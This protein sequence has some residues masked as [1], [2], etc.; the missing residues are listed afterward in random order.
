[1]C[2]FLQSRGYD[3]WVFTSEYCSVD[4]I[5]GLLKKYHV[6]PDGIITVSGRIEKTTEDKKKRIKDIINKKY[7]RTL[8]LYDDMMIVVNNRSGASNQIPLEGKGNEWVLSV[9]KVVKGLEESDE[10]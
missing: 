5:R 9:E 1:M 8:T 10:K 2:R 4:Y 6:E 3:V 7:L